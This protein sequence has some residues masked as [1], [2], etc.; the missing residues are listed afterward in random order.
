MNGG[1]KRNCRE[2]TNFM[3]PVHD[4]CVC[5]GI[6]RG[7]MEKGTCGGC[8]KFDRITAKMMQRTEV[9]NDKIRT[10]KKRVKLSS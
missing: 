7:R 5:P 2:H 4:I 1:C 10:L 9:R 8:D 6:C 3:C